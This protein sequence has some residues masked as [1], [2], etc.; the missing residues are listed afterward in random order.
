MN[1]TPEK[2]MSV[3]TDIPAPPASS[4]PVIA[5]AA[6]K[7]D[8]SPCR[9]L[10]LAGSPFCFWHGDRELVAA[11]GRK[12]SRVSHEHHKVVVGPGRIRLADADEIRKLLAS[13]VNGLRRGE[14]L[15][16]DANALCRLLSTGLKVVQLVELEKRIAALE[17]NAGST[18]GAR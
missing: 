4:I 14:L 16:T 5:C 8:G 11:A 10:A 3:P 15:A 2:P 18:K 12:G 9:M 6:V 7:A 13:A 1:E 17:G